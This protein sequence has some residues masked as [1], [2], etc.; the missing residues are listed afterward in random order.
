MGS[1]GRMVSGRGTWAAEDKRGS[2]NRHRPVRV[3]LGSRTAALWAAKIA[4]E[5]LTQ[6]FIAHGIPSQLAERLLRAAYVRESAKGVRKG[7][8]ED[9]NVSQISV[10]TGLDR[11]LVKA[12]LKNESEALR[13][14]EGRRDPITKVGD[15]W[16]TDPDYCTRRGPRDLPIGDKHSSRKS[17]CSLIERYVPGASARLVIDQLLRLNLVTALPNG[18]LRWVGSGNSADF[19]V[20][21]I[22]DDTAGA[23]LRTALRVLLH[24]LEPRNNDR[25]WRKAQSAAISSKDLPKV[26]KLLRERLDAM[27]SWL[28][29]ELAS[30]RWQT[31]ERGQAGVRI[32]LLGFS[33]EEP[34]SGDQKDDHG[35][36]ATR[37]KRDKA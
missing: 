33:F 24:N 13:I 18:K 10:K 30:S 14:P 36:S 35:T 1:T 21:P 32:G 28:T 12:I 16:L 6:A 7:W 2:T 22:E 34:V 11:H 5:E 4:F 8:R 37:I 17:V 19:S 15:G 3:P 23:Q 29:D 20:T 25:P 31:V 9:P 26:R 27:F